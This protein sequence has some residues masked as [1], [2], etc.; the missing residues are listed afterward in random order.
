[1]ALIYNPFYD[2]DCYFVSFSNGAPHRLLNRAAQHPEIIDGAVRALKPKYLLGHPFS[3][4]R[5]RLY[6]P[7][8]G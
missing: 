4:D 8:A 3:L 7:S 6:A 5:C 1:M 2:F